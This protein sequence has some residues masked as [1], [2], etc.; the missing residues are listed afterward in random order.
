MMW[1]ESVALE[2]RS[3]TIDRSQWR[4]VGHKIADLVYA[5]ITGVQGAFSTKIFYVLAKDAGS[6]Y[7]RL[8][9]RSG[10]C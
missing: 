5:K 10:R 3:F 8:S 1:L 7:A 2:S 4:D 6:S 9:V